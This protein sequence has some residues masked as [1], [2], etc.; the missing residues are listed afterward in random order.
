MDRTTYT[1]HDETDGDELELLSQVD[2]VLTAGPRTVGAA[3]MF[4]RGALATAPAGVAEI[5]GF[6]EWLAK[7]MH[8]TYMTGRASGCAELL[9]TDIPSLMRN[10]AKH[11]PDSY[12]ARVVREAGWATGRLNAMDLVQRAML[13]D[14][15][16]EKLEAHE[17]PNPVADTDNLSETDAAIAVVS[18]VIATHPDAS[19][20]IEGMPAGVETALR[21]KFPKTNFIQATP[22]MLAA[23]KEATSKKLH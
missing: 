4:T 14:L 20:S 1:P 5:P 18:K 10:I 12:A 19:I 22:E 8:T 17:M 9:N 2:D 7:I 11:V 23:I 21:A 15:A 13:G 3:A 6:S 16:G